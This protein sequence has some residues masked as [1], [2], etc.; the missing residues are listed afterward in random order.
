MYET[1]QRPWCKSRNLHIVSRIYR[2]MFQELE[3][4]G[5]LKGTLVV[6]EM[7]QRINKQD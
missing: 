3:C 4:K 6:Q 5:I 7:I 1:Y 2:Q